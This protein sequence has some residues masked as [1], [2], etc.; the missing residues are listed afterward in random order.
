MEKTTE[1]LINKIFYDPHAN[2][3]FKIMFYDNEDNVFV[4]KLLN[5]IIKLLI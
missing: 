2:Q 3:V 4:C 1:T 5:S